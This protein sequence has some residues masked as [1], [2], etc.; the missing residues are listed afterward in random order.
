MNNIANLRINMYANDC[1][2]Y[3][4]GNNWGN[5]IPKIQEGLHCFKNWCCKNSLKVN[6]RKS[7]SLILGSTYK[8][9]DKKL[10]NRLTLNVHEL[11]HTNVYNYLG[12]LLDKNMHMSLMPL[13]SRLKN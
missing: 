7:K 2:I 1:L 8:V 10:E 11:E 3:T 9:S 5:M 13:L 4:I 6:A 12:I